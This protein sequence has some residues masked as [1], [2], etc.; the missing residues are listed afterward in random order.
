[1]AGSDAVNTL[2]KE[3]AARASFLGATAAREVAADR[4]WAAYLKGD[5]P[6]PVSRCYR[7][8]RYRFAPST[9]AAAELMCSSFIRYLPDAEALAGRL[10]LV[11]DDGVWTWQCGT[12]MPARLGLQ[13]PVSGED[14]RSRGGIF[15]VAGDAMGETLRAAGTAVEAPLP[16]APSAWLKAWFGDAT[17]LGKLEEYVGEA[18]RWRAVLQLAEDFAWSVD[19]HAA[20]SAALAALCAAVERPMPIGQ[21]ESA[22]QQRLVRA[23]KQDAAAPLSQRAAAGWEGW[24]DASALA[25]DRPEDSGLERMFGSEVWNRPSWRDL[26][27]A[28]SKDEASG[29]DFVALAPV[30]WPGSKRPG[31]PTPGLPLL[32]ALWATRATQECFPGRLSAAREKLPSDGQFAWVRRVTL[33][34]RDAEGARID[35]VALFEDGVAADPDLAGWASR[36]WAVG[37]ARRESDV[38]AAYDVVFYAEG[39]DGPVEAP[40]SFPLRSFA[41]RALEV[42]RANLHAEAARIAVVERALRDLRV[43]GEFLPAVGALASAATALADA[44]PGMPFGL[45]VGRGTTGPL[46]AWLDSWHLVVEGF[47]QLFKRVGNLGGRVADGP[48]ATF[49]EIGTTRADKEYRLGA[50]ALL[51]QAHHPLRLRAQLDMERRALSDL[52]QTLNDLSSLREVPLR[53]DGDPGD[54]PAALWR[55]GKVWVRATSDGPFRAA[56]LPHEDPRVGEPDLVEAVRG[57]LGGLTHAVFPG[58]AR[59]ATIRLHGASDSVHGLRPLQLAS[60][61]PRLNPALTRG[62]DLV[63][64]S[65]LTD[66]PRDVGA[67]DALTDTSA[68]EQVLANIRASMT[69]RPADDLAFP[70]EVHPGAG[71]ATGVDGAATQ[72]VRVDAHVTLFVRPCSRKAAWVVRV[73]QEGDEGAGLARWDADARAWDQVRCSGSDELAR[74]FDALV[75]RR[76][77]GE[78]DGVVRVLGR[79]LETAATRDASVGGASFASTLED[80]AKS[81]LRVVIA[82]PLWGPEPLVFS[83]DPGALQVTYADFHR[84]S[85]WRVTVVADARHRPDRERNAAR[86]GVER[87]FPGVA[88]EVADMGFAATHR[89][90]PSVL[91]HLWSLAQSGEP[92]AE[93]LGHLGVSLFAHP[94]RGPIQR[95]SEMESQYAWL[96]EP[97]PAGSLLLSMDSL[98]RWTWTRRG[99]TRG[100]FLA[101]VPR[102]DSV[103]LLAVESKG[104]GGSDAANGTHQARTARDKLRARFAGAERAVERRE[105]LRCVGEEGFRAS[106]PPDLIADRLAAGAVEF[107]AVCVSTARGGDGFEALDEHGCLWLRACGIRGIEGLAG[108]RNENPVSIPSGTPSAAS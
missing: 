62:V 72:E 82:D 21:S 41:R 15:L 66:V 50:D 8:S 58:F 17:N 71:P 97:F 27:I 74:R 81:S 87:M 23:V 6:V 99:G 39:R 92:D 31:A 25:A 61:L 26:R 68:E 9:G 60:A 30:P 100:D 40:F 75:V 80:A 1:M 57:P 22:P 84:P 36:L 46:Q 65:A 98:Q 69:L 43:G 88:P 83:P 56:Y 70:L 89:A 16:D 34:R 102:G 64:D 86:R 59:R 67:L 77:R 24:A 94:G 11:G 93:S 108:T 28:C 32:D 2:S 33:G 106:A 96:S 103:V 95:I 54:V 52:T 79:C 90:V 49:L 7:D 101:L 53:T 20:W 104:S 10:F 76:W 4:V 44:P 38:D 5:G 13:D 19:L 73:A 51:V 37:Q 63:V 105:L 91:L 35:E 55:H 29:A 45:L 12:L 42:W 48:L 85:G 107:G 47:F 14:C 3:Q 18:G 78:E